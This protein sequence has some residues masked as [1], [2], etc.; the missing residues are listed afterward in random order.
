[1]SILEALEQLF[2]K[3]ERVK[4]FGIVLA[5]GWAAIANRV[6]AHL[7]GYRLRRFIYRN[8]FAMKIGKGSTLQMGTFI[9]APQRISI[10]THTNVGIGALLDGRGCV[11]I[12]SN[13]DINFVVSIFTLE[14]NI[15]ANDYSSKGGPVIIADYAC[16]ASGATI[17]PN[18]C[19]G[20][21]A[22]IAAGAVVTKNVEDFSVVGG[23]PARVIGR[24]REI[25][26]VH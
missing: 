4:R 12:G 17:L 24:R 26:S 11:V 23:V 19:I 8:L 6:I 2:K 3:D 25:S 15:N 20:R 22:V 18:I 16:I 10:G 5:C 7:P 9:L 13:V 14:H 21:G 1:M